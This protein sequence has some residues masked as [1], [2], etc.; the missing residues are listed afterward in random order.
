MV[1][2]YSFLFF[3]GEYVREV[4]GQV[5]VYF[6]SYVDLLARFAGYAVDDDSLELVGHGVPGVVVW[7]LPK[8]FMAVWRLPE[9]PFTCIQPIPLSC[10]LRNSAFGLQVRVI[11]R[12]YTEDMHVNRSL[13]LKYRFCVF[14]SALDCKNAGGPALG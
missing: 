5:F 8:S 13:M 14:F 3:H 10:A 6:S 11:R 2:K 1:K 9:A 12:Q 4:S 7:P